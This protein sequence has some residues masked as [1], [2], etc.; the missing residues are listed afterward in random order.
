MDL[1]SAVTPRLDLTAC[2]REPIHIVGSVQPH[3]FLLTLEAASLAIVQ[4]SAN[5]PA[6]ATV[7][8]SLDAVLPELAALVRHY[9]DDPPN[10]DGALYLRTVI[11]ES[12]AASQAYEV[13]AHRVGGLVVLELEEIADAAA[14]AGLDALTPRLRAFVQRLRLARSV[15]DLCEIVAADIRHVTGFDRV[16]VYRFDRDW[17]GTVLAEDGNGV[18]PSYL[19]LRFPASDIPVQA[20]ELYRRN[21]LRIIPDAGYEP[22]PIRPSLTPE[23]KPLDLSQSVLR[24]VSP[25]HVEYM[26]NMGTGAS[27]SV[28]ILVDDVLWGL[29]SCHNREPH[30]VPLQARNAC[31]ILTQIFA[32]QL[33]A[34][35]RGAQAEQRLALGAV[36][37]RLLGFMAEE[38][39]FVDG[40]L[41]H[42]DDVMAL[43]N[44]AGAAIVT[45]DRCRLIGTTPSEQEVRLLHDWLSAQDEAAEVFATETLSELLPAADAF[46][47]RASGLLAISV[48][49]KYA[50]YI[51]WFRP[52]VVRTVKWGG[53]PVKPAQ[54]DPE[55]GPDRLHPRK[56]FETWKET[57]KGR[58]LPWSVPEVEAAKDLRSSVLGIVLRRAEE[59]AAMSE[60]LQRSN[61]ELEA[62]SYSVSHDL[63]APFRHIVGY[64][65]LLKNR[66]GANLSDKGRHYVETIIEAAFSAGTL[67]D[68]LLTFSQMGRH[69]LNRV[70]GDM[71]ALVEEVRRKA[72]RDVL[73]ERT[74]RWEIGPLGRAYAD[75][76]MLRL[77]LENL[78]SNALKYTRDR[79]EA[80]IAV[81]RLPPSD[82]EAV[83]FV[84]DNG[85]GFDMAYVDKLFGVFQRLHRVEEFEGTGIGLANVR[86][87][88]ERHGGRTWAEGK[89][90]EGA[91]FHFTLPLRGEGH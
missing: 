88:V 17:H 41:N 28:S 76:F 64:S 2:D 45:G 82:G 58:S 84:R 85:V 73:P 68:N 6:A 77:V 19:D 21:R 65:N 39:S 59:L 61:K 50:S 5:A 87:I 75:P 26:R 62:F 3:G 1:R 30:R 24:S 81:G 37:A 20:R 54:P 90:G 49:K 36:Q 25:V 44:A 34:R 31:D 71:N 32:L 8:A 66:E 22:V 83:F 89:L 16:L 56:S 51:L 42:P 10:E 11:L 27:M 29:V 12:G 15:E 14:A 67:V 43:V 70:A 23:G 46:A 79:P 7:G 48:S 57:V 4:A 78:L 55:G 47:D 38:D 53:N 13:A 91:T 18:L 86:R 40:L 52:E 60:E 72:M 69:A 35:E 63:R 74:I 80:V 9:L 33:S